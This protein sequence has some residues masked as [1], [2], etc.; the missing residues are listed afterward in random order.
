MYPH[1]IV[2]LGVCQNSRSSLYYLLTVHIRSEF[3]IKGKRSGG[4]VGSPNLADNQPL[5]SCLFIGSPKRLKLDGEV[6]DLYLIVSP[7]LQTER[8]SNRPQTDRAE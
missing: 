1:L 5:A 6:G 3:S 4:F 2:V 7:S 8:P